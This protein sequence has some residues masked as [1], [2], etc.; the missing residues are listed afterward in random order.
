MNDND[1]NIVM[2]LLRT[3]GFTKS[4]F[5]IPMY[6]YTYSYIIVRIKF[7]VTLANI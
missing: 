7:F 2:L 1:Y 5:F 6:K 4:K 3:N